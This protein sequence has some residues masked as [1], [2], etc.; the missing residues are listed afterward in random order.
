MESETEKIK[1]RIDKFKKDEK[2]GWEGW[3]EAW[4]R[5]IDK[6]KI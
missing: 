3:E 2:H 4:E 6:S 5:K 1:N